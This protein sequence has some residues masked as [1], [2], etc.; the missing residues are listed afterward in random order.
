V[1]EKQKEREFLILCGTTGAADYLYD[2]GSRPPRWMNKQEKDVWFEGY[3]KAKRAC[4][5]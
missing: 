1:T 3:N 5:R 2:Q 4:T